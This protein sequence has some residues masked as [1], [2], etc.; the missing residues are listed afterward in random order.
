MDDKSHCSLPGSRG[1]KFTPTTIQSERERRRIRARE[2]S[3][4]VSSTPDRIT[5]RNEGSG[6]PCKV[7]RFQYVDFPSLHQ[8][9]QQLSVPPL[10]SWLAGC[11]MGLDRDRGRPSPGLTPASPKER[12]PKFKYVD[13]PSLY[14]CIQQLSVPPL[15][16][17]SSGLPQPRGD[18]GSGAK[19]VE[20]T[21]SQSGSTR[22]DQ[23]TQTAPSDTSDT[24]HVQQGECAA[25]PLPRRDLAEERPSPAPL[26]SHKRQHT[27]PPPRI[28]S[29]TASK[30]RV[31]KGPSDQG[32]ALSMT[33]GYHR[34]PTASPDPDRA[35]PRPGS[36]G[37]RPSVINLHPGKETPM[38][39]HPQDHLAG[40]PDSAQVASNVHSQSVCTICQKMFAGPEELRKHQEKH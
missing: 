28:P 32:P 40:Y 34:R 9:I 20:R 36:K 7:P 12:A 37:T 24:G 26:T 25:F 19:T 6:I 13:Y 15:E 27:A 4:A 29:S 5:K 8:C 33:P 1:S 38:R 35:S 18:N 30:T 14:H 10:E 11:R 21:P 16:S 2:Q 22:E 3:N 39:H 31:L 17:W 23:A